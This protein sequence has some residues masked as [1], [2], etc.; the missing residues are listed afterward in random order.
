MPSAGELVRASDVIPDSLTS[1]TPTWSSSGTQPVL[2]NGT[3]TGEYCQVG[4]LVFVKIVL[5]AGSTTTFGTST[6]RFSLPV[7]PSLDSTL[8]A[9]VHDSSA[10]LRWGGTVWIILASTTGDNMRIAISDGAGGVAATV[11]MTFANGDKIM[12]SGWYPAN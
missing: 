4:K 11:P 3:L 10:A 9:V 1:F 6:Y 8:S 5:T 2:G 12:I 7:T